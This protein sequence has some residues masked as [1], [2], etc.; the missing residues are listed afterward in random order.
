MKTAKPFRQKRIQYLARQ[1]NAM[2]EPHQ[3]I[4]IRSS[5]KV[6]RELGVPNGLKRVKSSPRPTFEFLVRFRH[7]SSL[8][9]TQKHQKWVP[10][11]TLARN[12]KIK[13]KLIQNFAETLL[14]LSHKK[15]F[16]KFAGT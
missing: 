9:S 8:V 5:E 4:D 10:E 6:L 7:P 2:T 15:Q 14:E 11:D 12:N 1:N 13:I 16:E 3:I